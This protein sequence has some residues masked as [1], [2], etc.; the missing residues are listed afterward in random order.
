MRKNTLKEKIDQKQKV[1]GT[2]LMTNSQDNAEILGHTG[3]DFIMIDAEHG[4]MDLES[5]GRM[6]S[7][8]RG[9]QAT[10]LLRVAGNEKS[11]IKKG[12]DTGASGVM[13]PM[14]NTEEEAKDAVSYCKYPPVGVRGMG[15][16]R[17]VLFG[18]AAEEYEDY[19][20]QANEEVLVIVQ[21]EHYEA[22]EN[23]AEILSVPNIDIAFVGPYDLSTSMGLPGQV[24]H[25]DVIKNFQKVI[26]ACEKFNVT[27]GIMTWTDGIEQ[28]LEMGFKFLLGGMDGAILYNGV[29]QLVTEFNGFTK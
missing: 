23:I 20:A 3:V 24:N 15:A 27:P 1:F 19:Y 8:I 21:I 16:G 7:V 22:V 28:H 5:A 10:P 11:L 2:W 4:S 29:K 18:A 12:L 13:I 14:V 6:V 9:T 25:P 26:T 17:A